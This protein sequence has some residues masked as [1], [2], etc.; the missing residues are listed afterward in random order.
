[1]PG[2]VCSTSP[3]GA[4][5]A[6]A[7]AR[8]C[9]TWS[10]STDPVSAAD[11]LGE[12]GDAVA[13]GV[14]LPALGAHQRGQVGVAAGAQVGA[15]AVEGADGEQAPAEQHG[16]RH[17]DPP[18][19]PAPPRGAR[20]VAS[21]LE[22]APSVMATKVSRAPRAARI[23]RVL[24]RPPS[25]APLVP[26]AR[27]VTQCRPC[28]GPVGLHRP[29]AGADPLAPVRCRPAAR[30]GR[31]RLDR[32]LL[33]GRARRPDRVPRARARQAR[34]HGRPGEVELR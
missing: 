25:S 21:G 12:P 8:S 30:G 22:S 3:A 6:R 15:T 23:P 5:R 33:R 20:T 26:A 11:L 29:R 24:A 10:L 9:S 14:V 2:P 28:P 19:R 1:M 34:L 17:D 27:G 32:L 18:G 7:W 4:S 31:H 16:H 13:Q